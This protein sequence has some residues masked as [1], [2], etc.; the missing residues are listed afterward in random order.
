MFQDG[1]SRPQDDMHDSTARQRGGYHAQNSVPVDLSPACSQVVARRMHNAV[2][3]RRLPTP[4]EAPTGASPSWSAGSTIQNTPPMSI[5]LV[6]GVTVAME[7]IEV[8]SRG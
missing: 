1:L 8:V 7:P 6:V 5:G 4:S 2:S 3:V